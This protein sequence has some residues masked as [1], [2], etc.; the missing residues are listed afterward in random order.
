[1]KP[2]YPLSAIALAMGLFLSG[3]AA[4]A[5]LQ[6]SE[7]TP[8]TP[9]S[10]VQ[11]A[12][13]QAGWDE[14]PVITEGVS[15]MV[16]ITPTTLPDSVR[17]RKVELELDPDA[18]VGDLVAVLGRLGVTA[19]ISDKDVAGRT[20]YLPRYKG[21]VGGLLSAVTRAT[22]TWF[23]WHDGSV[24]VTGKEKISVSVPQEADFGT[25]LSKGL[26]DLGVTG[27]AVSWQAG[28]ATMELTPKEFTKVRTFLERF[29]SNSAVVTIQMAVV[30]V[31]LKQDVKQGI[32]WEKLSISA[33]AKGTKTDLAG[34]S[35]SGGGVAA[36][37]TGGQTG[38]STANNGN[39]TNTNSTTNN[40]TNGTSGGN[41][42]VAAVA[43]ATL[44]G[45]AVVAAKIASG[46]LS[47]ALFSNRFSFE[48]LFGFLETYGTAET[49]QNV[50]LKT[51]T[52]SKVEFK[53]LTQIPYVS[54]VSVTSTANA[55]N[56]SNL[57]SSQTA[58][59]DDGITVELTPSYDA[60]ANSVTID[61]KL[62]IKAVLGFNELSAG[63]QL[64]TLSQPTTAER[65]FTDKLRVR[66]GQTVVVGGLTYDSVSDNR[67]AP[68]YLQKSSFESQT[69]KVDRQ[70][71][72]IVLRPTV[73]RLG[74]VL[75]SETGQSLDLLPQAP[76]P[77]KVEEK[78]GGKK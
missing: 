77:V 46:N 61:F 74:Q 1:M 8:A 27:S 35:P 60:A 65:S 41:N 33:L 13:L 29:T 59:A 63:N 78:K 2:R 34:W 72:F 5:P 70:T 20:F 67:G 21:T 53:S 45:P 68:L 6:H 54:E 42:A 25:E 3:C 37:Q 75:T 26:T 64:G 58:K 32:D 52:G 69:L 7:K 38:N 76:E 31:T 15:S 9:T 36:P 24:V 73:M 10:A 56:N 57:G 49:K 11:S 12:T 71:T 51:V 28:M 22:D 47:A 39:N 43:Q 17:N 23:V 19:I 50:M 18:T 14:P 66:P 62:A 48:G 4:V 44:S 40:G 16:L 55:N 30:N